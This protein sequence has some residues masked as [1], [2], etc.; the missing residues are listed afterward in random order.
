MF[1]QLQSPEWQL[2]E[3][4]L[5]E[6]PSTG[7]LMD[8]EATYLHMCSTDDPGL[9]H[10]RWNQNDVQEDS[11]QLNLRRKTKYVETNFFLDQKDREYVNR[12]CP[13]DLNYVQQDG[14]CTGTY[15]NGAF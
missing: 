15:V 10:L 3:V 14:S 7:E 13:I 12:V 9:I 11:F 6:N 8:E 1:E 2:C 5:T 4:T